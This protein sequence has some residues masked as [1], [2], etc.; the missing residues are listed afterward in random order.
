MEAHL[1]CPLDTATVVV[2]ADED[3]EAMRHL[4]DLMEPGQPYS[5]AR[6]VELCQANGCFDG[7]VGEAG[8]ELENAGR[9]TLARLLGRYGDRLVKHCRFVI[10]GK[11]HKRCY[12]IKVVESA[13]RLHAPHAVS[14]RSGEA[15]Y[16]R[17]DREER[18]ER[19][20]R[21]SQPL[22]CKPLEGCEWPG[23]CLTF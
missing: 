14:T 22:A 6:V 17:T 11:G 8:T 20:E 1:R 21:A 3:S 15:P 16:V 7:L 13:A 23:A 10:E 18:V 9:V 4:I 5:F 2:A 19:A 12:H